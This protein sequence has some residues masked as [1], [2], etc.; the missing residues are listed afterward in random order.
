[1][2]ITVTFTPVPLVH[3]ACLAYKTARPKRLPPGWL[4]DSAGA[5]MDAWLEYLEYLAG[6]A[7]RDRRLSRREDRAI[8]NA[9]L[10]LDPLEKWLW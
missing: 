2:Q 4:V 1:M 8:Q 10:A 7:P 6:N 3:P 9:R 5:E